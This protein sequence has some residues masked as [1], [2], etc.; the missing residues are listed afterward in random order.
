MIQD[1]TVA[2]FYASQDG[3]AVGY[4]AVKLDQIPCRN[5]H[6]FTSGAKLSSV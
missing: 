5:L 2:Y 6:N 4:F 1:S 3:T